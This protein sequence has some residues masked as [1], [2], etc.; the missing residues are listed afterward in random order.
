MFTALLALA[1]LTLLVSRAG[2]AGHTETYRALIAI[3]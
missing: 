1:F 2:V 3:L